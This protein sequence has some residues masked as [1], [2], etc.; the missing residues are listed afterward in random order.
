VL[1]SLP[2]YTLSLPAFL[3]DVYISDGCSGCFAVSQ[4]F[5]LN[6]CHGS[7]EQKFVGLQSKRKLL[8][9]ILCLWFLIVAD[10]YLIDLLK[11]LIILY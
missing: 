4:T 7:A 5:S 9:T 6:V 8:V 10:F 2:R 3:T 1:K 11:N